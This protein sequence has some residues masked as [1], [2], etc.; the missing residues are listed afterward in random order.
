M[1]RSFERIFI[2]LIICLMI[3]ANS[4]DGIQKFGE[5]I[6]VEA[7]SKR[8]RKMNKIK[9]PKKAKKTK[10]TK[11]AKKTKKK[12][13]QKHKNKKTPIYCS[14]CAQAV[15]IGKYTA[16]WK[17]GEIVVKKNKKRIRSTKTGGHVSEN[18]I[19]TGSSLVYPCDEALEKMDIKTGKKK[20]LDFT[21][22]FLKFA[23]GKYVYFTADNGD[24]SNNLYVWNT[25]KNS[26]QC[27]AGYITSNIMCY[28]NK[29][30]Y[31]YETGDPGSSCICWKK[32]GDTVNQKEHE[33]C[34]D[35][36][37]TDDWGVFC[38]YKDILMYNK[39]EWNGADRFSFTPCK[40][41]LKTGEKT[42]VGK[43]FSYTYSDLSFAEKEVTYFL[44]QTHR[45]FIKVPTVNIYCFD[46]VTGEIKSFDC[47]GYTVH[48]TDSNYYYFCV[49][50]DVYTNGIFEL[51]RMSKE[52][53]KP[54]KI[55]VLDGCPSAVYGN[56]VF[57]GKNKKKKIK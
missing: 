45:I 18:F 20:K 11:K 53:G 49:G 5:T 57:Y 55:A 39:Y 40:L 3:L 2:L 12:K 29:V 19:Y 31:Q 22:A 38:I 8:V 56:T 32:V 23:V 50:N 26:C 24:G 43:Q 37:G 16:V 28:K 42:L 33:V 21:K 30:Y 34:H 52:R 14:E 1:K 17:D 7:A 44:N 25:S 6:F 15:M 35:I 51:Y 48:S 4:V 10:K 27:V 36:S 13:T 54:Q 47:K 41:N 46:H 9:K